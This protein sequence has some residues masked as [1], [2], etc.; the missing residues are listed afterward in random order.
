MLRQLR[1]LLFP[2]RCLF[3]YTL[4]EKDTLHCGCF[5]PFR[6]KSICPLCRELLSRCRCKGSVE[7][8]T[9]PFFYQ[10]PVRRQLL[11]LKRTPDPRILRFFGY[12]LKE[13]IEARYD[14]YTLDGI[15]PIPISPRGLKQRGFN[16]AELLA[17]EVGVLLHLPVYTTLLQREN[18]SQP[19]H[20][21]PYK[22]RLLNAET[23]FQ[24]HPACPSLSDQKLLLVDDIITSGATLNACGQALRNQGASS[25]VAATVAA[26]QIKSK[27]EERL[28]HP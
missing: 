25:V 10:E 21:L 2:S 13:S 6:K 5:L 4:V 7:E 20:G 27:E 17:K 12:W 8:I 15:V 26:A 19:Q 23:S 18:H 3:C 11:T 16:Q 9:A 1:H 28:W 14:P 22:E 24:S